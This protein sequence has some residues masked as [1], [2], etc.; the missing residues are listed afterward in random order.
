MIQPIEHPGK[1]SWMY[2]D[3]WEMHIP[4][5]SQP[6]PDG[7]VCLQGPLVGTQVIDGDCGEHT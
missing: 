3:D 2:D 7:K 5:C 4:C 6:R 1:A